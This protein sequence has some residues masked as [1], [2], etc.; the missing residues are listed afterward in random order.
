MLPILWPAGMFCEKPFGPVHTVFTVTGT[1]TALCN[2][3][4]HV[5]TTLTAPS[6]GMGLDGSLVTFTE[7]GDGTVLGISDH[8]INTHSHFPD[9]VLTFQ[10][11]S[12]IVSIGHHV[13]SDSAAVH[14]SI[15]QVE[16]WPRKHH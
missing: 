11:H 6:V 2:L 8:Y 15:R 12:L 5:R 10:C 9:L 14:S 4:V 7:T 1:S 16:H 13:H 3:T